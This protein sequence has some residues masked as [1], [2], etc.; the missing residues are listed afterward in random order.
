MK[1]PA[2]NEQLVR[3]YLLDELPERERERLEVGL[4]TDDRYCETLSAL[5]EEVGDDLIE[6][7]L[8]GELTET[9]RENFERVFLN[10]PDRAHKIKVIKDLKDH[11]TP[12][13]ELE[14]PVQRIVK[15]EP[16]YRRR[17]PAIGIFQNPLFGFSTAVALA[18]AL[19][20]C[21]WLW[22]RSSRLETELMQARSQHDPV[23]REQVE[24]LNRRNEELTARLQRSEEQR[25]A[26]EQQ[27][28]ALKGGLGQEVVPPEQNPQPSGGTIA[29]VILT[30][31]LRSN[32]SRPVPTLTL[33]TG[34]TV[35]RLVVNVER[36]DPADY[37]RFRAIVQRQGGEEVWRSEDVKLRAR[38]NNARA[39]LDISAEK[40]TEGQYVGA[41]DGITLDDQIEPIG[42]YVFRVQR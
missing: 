8:D 41:L 12:E 9:E 36:I 26:A 3:R 42:R 13:A 7:Y 40:L 30:S 24:Q 6:E 10:S 4:L 1:T 28:A 29:S 23:L 25:A 39:V 31:S 34:V 15:T 14:A 18:L 33:K 20:F 17:I 21:A 11:S 22:T 27:V 38:G 2:L 32:G 19:V 37:K 5:E 16:R 35:A